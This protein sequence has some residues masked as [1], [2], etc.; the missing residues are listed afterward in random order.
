[1]YVS[2]FSCIPTYAQ[3]HM[4][5]C[6]FPTESSL[7]NHCWFG[8]SIT[9]FDGFIYFLPWLFFTPPAHQAFLVTD[10][11]YQTF[12]R[13]KPWTAPRWEH[14]ASLQRTE[15]ALPAEFRCSSWSFFSLFPEES[16]RCARCPFHFFSNQKKAVP[17]IYAKRLLDKFFPQSWCGHVNFNI[18]SSLE[19]LSMLNLPQAS[20]GCLSSCFH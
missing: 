12:H 8:S 10:A 6:T 2:P 7:L 19:D 20:D 1:M 3:L 13:S 17:F 5:Y 14:M 15:T 4:L 11:I 18:I 9:Y 16:T